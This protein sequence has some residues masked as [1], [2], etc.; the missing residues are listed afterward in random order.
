LNPPLTRPDA[1]SNATNDN[2]FMSISLGSPE[3]LQ[4]TFGFGILT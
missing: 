4:S 2:S 3:P 1:I